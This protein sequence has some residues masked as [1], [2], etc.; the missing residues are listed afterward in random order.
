MT[1]RAAL[2]E[3]AARVEALDRPC[4]QADAE[5]KEAVNHSWDYA[6]DWGQRG[7]EVPRAHAY[8]ASIDAAMTLVPEGWAIK[9]EIYEDG[10][11]VALFDDRVHPE[12]LP[13]VGG[14]AATPALALTAACLRAIA[15]K[16]G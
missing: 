6:A 11:Y 16:E 1:N 14:E 13:D 2:E 7:H 4:W 3:L 5:I 9:I 12:R 15:G 8:T 10:S